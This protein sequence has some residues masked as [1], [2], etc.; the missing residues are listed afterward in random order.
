MKQPW[1]IALVYLA[2]SVCVMAGENVI[3]F[4]KPAADWKK[5]QN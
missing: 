5:W 4:D 2:T 1:L 3:W